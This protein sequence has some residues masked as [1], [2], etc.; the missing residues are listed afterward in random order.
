MQSG[1][2]REVIT[3]Q[4]KSETL[5]DS[6]QVEISW[7]TFASGVY[8]GIETVSGKEF[9]AESKYNAQISHVVRIRYSAGVKPEMRVLWGSRVLNIAH[10]GEDRKHANMMVLNCMEDRN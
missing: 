6:R 2:L 5:T 1:K 4:Q 7:V 8:A 9:Y 3:I 10:I